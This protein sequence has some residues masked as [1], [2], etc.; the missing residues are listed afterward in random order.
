MVYQNR[1]ESEL[2]FVL[3]RFLNA[4]HLQHELKFPFK[5]LGAIAGQV[6]E[7]KVNE[8]IAD[9]MNG[10]SIPEL[11]KII[12]ICSATVETPDPKNQKK[13]VTSRSDL[14]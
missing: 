4:L 7:V 8:L 6:M 13:K 3:E 1:D 11:I 9:V 12:K 5:S 10:F 14:Q 2:K